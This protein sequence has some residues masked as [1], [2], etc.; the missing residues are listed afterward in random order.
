VTGE[1]R[2]V[3]AWLVGALERQDHRFTALLRGNPVRD[4]A[5]MRAQT[6][7]ALGKGRAL[8]DQHEGG[9]K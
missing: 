7:H 6:E 4:V 8:L 9:W 1:E 5:E 2:D 3:V